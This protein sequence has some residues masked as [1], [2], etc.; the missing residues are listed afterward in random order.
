MWNTVVPLCWDPRGPWPERAQG[1]NEQDRTHKG[2]HSLRKGMTK[3]ISEGQKADDQLAKFYFSQQALYKSWRDLNI[4]TLW[5]SYNLSVFAILYFYCQCPW[6]SI[7]FF[8]VKGN[9][10]VFLPTMIETWCTCSFQPCR[11]AAKP[12]QPCQTVASGSQHLWSHFILMGRT[13]FQ[14]HLYKLVLNTICM[15]RTVLFFSLRGTGLWTCC[16]VGVT[17]TLFHLS[18]SACKKT[19]LK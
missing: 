2:T 17:Q 3:H 6:L 1:R 11:N 5:P 10:L 12:Q 8:S 4:K 15:K 7:N 16:L 14:H 18:H 19:V 13:S 9:H